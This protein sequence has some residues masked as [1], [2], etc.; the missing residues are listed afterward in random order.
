[1]NCYG[2]ILSSYPAGVVSA[3]ATLSIA[4]LIVVFTLHSV[5]DFS[6][7]QLGFECRGTVLS[8]RAV[9]WENLL[10]ASQRAG[11]LSINP[12]EST[13]TSASSSL[14]SNEAPRKK[15]KMKAQQRTNSTSGGSI[16]SVEATSSWGAVRT[17]SNS[18]D[19]DGRESNKAKTNKVWET[20]R[21]QQ[22]ASQVHPFEVLRGHG[23]SKDAIA[24]HSHFQWG[25]TV[26]RSPAHPVRHKPMWSQLQ[27]LGTAGFLR[28][29]EDDREEGEEEETKKPQNP[30]R[31]SFYFCDQPHVE[32]AHVIFASAGEQNRSLW[33]VE[34]IQSMCRLD[35]LMRSSPLFPTVCQQPAHQQSA[36][37][38]CCP[39]WTLGHYVALMRNRSSCSDI[40]AADVTIV[41]NILEACS[42][43][44]HGLQLS[45]NCDSIVQ[46]GS[47][48][49]NTGDCGEDVPEI[50]TRHNA[51]YH[52]FHYLTDAEFL[53]GG[54][55]HLRYAAVFLPV[56]R[57]TALLPY[58]DWLDSH[59]EFWPLADNYTVAVAMDFGL[60]E[61]LFNEY[62][63]RDVLFLSIGAVL[64]CTMMWWYTA[65]LF[66]TFMAI[67]SV[68]LSLAV[69]YFV[70]TF[71]FELDF[72]P[73]MNLLAAVIVVGIGAD[74]VFVYIQVWRCAKL[75]KDGT[76]LPK[77]V[78]DTLGHAGLSMLVTSLTTAAAFF[79]SFICP[80]TAIRCFSLF[81]GLT[82][83]IHFLFML[84]WLPASVLLAEKY[85]S[86]VCRQNT[87]RSVP[88]FVNS[89]RSCWRT[90]SDLG[91]ITFDKILPCIV[92][93][94]R[95]FWI[96]LLGGLA[97][98]AGVVVFH[99]PKLELPDTKEF[100]L[101]SSSHPFE[102]YD[103]EF[104]HEFWFERSQR[105]E[106]L[107]KL[108]L[109]FVWGV[110]AEDNGNYLDPSSKG[111]LVLDPTF[112]MAAPESQEWLSRF[113]KDIR[114]QPFFQPTLGPLLPN[115]FIETFQSWMDRR[116]EDS[117]DRR[118]RTPCCELST[119]PYAED[120]FNE[121][122]VLAVKDLYET[123]AQ[124]FLP[125]VAGPRFSKSTQRVD[126]VVIEYDS[127][128]SYSLS[129]TEMNDFHR[130]VEQWMDE[131]LAKAPLGM[132]GG[133]FTSDLA[134]YDVQR[135]LSEGTV[136]AIALAMAIALLVLICA[137]GNLWLSFISVVCLT[138]VV[139]VSVAVL[140]LLGW[141]LNILE[142][143]SVSLAV[144][145]S[146]D[147]TL[148]YAVAYRLSAQETDRES[149]VVFSLSRMSSPIAM[150]A[151]TTLS[152]GAAVLPSSVVAYQQIGTFVVVVMITSWIYST[153][154]LP[155]MLRVCGPQNGCSQI[156]C[157]SCAHCFRCCCPNSPTHVDKTV[158]SYGLSESTLST[159]STSCPNPNANISTVH[160]E[161]HELEPL[162]SSHRVKA[163]RGRPRSGS[164]VATNDNLSS[165]SVH[166]SITLAKNGRKMRKISLPS[167]ALLVADANRE[168]EVVCIETQ[169]S[170]MWAA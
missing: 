128:I 71:L 66:L 146:V 1:M 124:F 169:N 131:Q 4:C 167:T 8:R 127:N 156:R 15:N 76:T 65:S 80:V 59:D 61:S 93:K 72:F 170:D 35:E 39:S 88:I 74:D 58:F 110:A 150:A 2:R 132:K 20:K 108:P 164:L 19:D 163:V 22:K 160:C 105:A 33:N 41:F 103:M 113:C 82:V 16:A 53:V 55:Q 78:M 120:V 140:V 73:F 54:N 32:Y 137:T 5:P 152:A 25:E 114:D 69:A 7:P 90:V 31:N 62:M 34:S 86:P 12:L 51:V 85:F 158:Y 21:Q 45:P 141:K 77:L 89:F 98:A 26:T 159:S 135:S 168:P 79:S 60:K 75:D 165:T 161:A 14:K 99:Y 48:W 64:I 13:G 136:S 145:L 144:G 133:W 67:V 11:P 6:D 118:N 162:T 149:S 24:N 17:R 134:F 119:F 138:S 123:P 49:P 81:A 37:H 23:T 84:S 42:R 100:Q 3:V 155:S 28:S 38:Q 50:C 117:F 18:L 97:V 46:E 142:S 94:F 112:N 106:L 126:A 116:C 122:I 139:L 92:V 43:H 115:C 91:R 47:S 87:G 101:F 130:Q 151:V 143:V 166:S 121:C 36:H 154:F 70:Y 96:A 29:D 30:S 44:Y 125:G 63:V 153:L 57:S 83:T 56:A 107:A 52:I 111:S 27:Q 102:R 148:H 109:R 147:F 129:Y 10:R 68:I 104:K 40:D 157:P 9:A 95:Y